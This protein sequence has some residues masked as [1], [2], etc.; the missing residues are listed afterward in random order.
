MPGWIEQHPDV[1]LRLMPRLLRSQLHRVS[2]SRGQVAHLEVQV[3]H[4]LLRLAGRGPDRRYV[5]GAALKGKVRH[6][7]GRRNGR[8][9]GVFLHQLP[10]QKLGVNRAKPPAS[11][12]SSTTPQ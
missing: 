3:H 2:G 12:A 11:G 1:G 6:P 7:L 8:T 10:V 9:G 4:H 5:V